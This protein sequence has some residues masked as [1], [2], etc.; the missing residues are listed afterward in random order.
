VAIASIAA[1][2]IAD[3]AAGLVRLGREEMQGIMQNLESRLLEVARN[4]RALLAGLAV[5]AVFGLSIWV[6]PIAA[7]VVLAPLAL[8]AAIAAAPNDT[9]VRAREAAR[10]SINAGL[11][12]HMRSGR[13]L[14][15]LDPHT[16]LLQRWYFELRVADE[17]RRCRRYGMG[18]ST[19]FIK[20]EAD[21]ALVTDPDWTTEVQMDVIQVFARQ[22]RAV[23]LAS[24]I[25][26]REFAL[27]LP[28]TGEQGAMS[29]AWRISQ[30]IGAYQVTVRKAMAPDQGL[31]FDAL[32][33]VAE[34]FTPQDTAAKPV[35]EP[36]THLQLVQLVKSSP[37]GEVPVPD[38]QTTRNTKSKLR[39]AAKRAGVDVRIW[40]A[41]GTI[42]FERLAGQ[43][44]RGVA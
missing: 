16:G 29:L 20:I 3:E 9:A 19:L 37:Y 33:E 30:N 39:R 7:A 14:S 21:E 18:M 38:G 22:M 26:D 15:I 35:Q 13:R 36:S 28:H 44:Q 27:C 40:E 10:A 32:Y 17:A 43:S 8:I 34:A 25:D 5:L 2:K 4:P 41:D 12:R 6:S 23:D 11:N 31:D 1:A 24:R 42:H